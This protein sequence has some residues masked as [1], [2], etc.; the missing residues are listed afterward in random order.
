MDL[1]AEIF[2]CSIFKGALDRHTPNKERFVL[3]SWTFPGRRGSVFEE[4]ASSCS[5]IA[6]DVDEDE[7]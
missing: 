2:V 4:A 1:Q 7:D 5:I 3:A 6:L